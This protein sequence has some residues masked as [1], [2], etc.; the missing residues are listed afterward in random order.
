MAL[1]G[2]SIKS[3]WEN[4]AQKWLLDLLIVANVG[5]AIYG[6]YWY[7]PQFLETSPKVWVLVADSPIS[8]ALFALAM[9]ALARG[10]A[11]QWQPGLLF[12]ASASVIKYGIWAV[13]IISEYWLSGYSVQPLH[14]GLWLSHV[15]MAVEGWIFLRHLRV[16]R[17]AVIAVGAWM[18]LNDTADYVFG[19]HPYLYTPDQW[20][21]AVVSA[22]VLSLA[23]IA[24]GWVRQETIQN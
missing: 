21:L 14:L 16:G 10:W 8:A 15:G 1:L 6:F 13:V 12:L 23:L 19:L 7:L 3:L 17:L 9:L 4:P 24:S 11:E 18:L 22:S 20:L 5:G 2:R